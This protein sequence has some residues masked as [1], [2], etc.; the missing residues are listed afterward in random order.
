VALNCAALAE[1]LLESELFGHEKGAFTGATQMKRGRFELAH[2]GT[3]FLDEIG[4]MSVNLQPK[5][6]RVLQERQFERLG[7]GERLITVDVRVIAATNRDLAHAMEE[8]AF[9]EDLYYRL[10]V[11]PIQIPPLRDRREDIIPLAEH[12][13]GKISARMGEP[14]KPLSPEM[15]QILSGYDWPGNVRELQNA[16]ERA[17]IN[18]GDRLAVR[19]FRSTRFQ[20]A[21]VALELQNLTTGSAL[22]LRGEASAPRTAE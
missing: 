4:D 10:N 11:F 12:F 14:P 5:L 19:A 13:A 15:Q 2:T 1:T 3:L 18:P 7:G 22:T 9:R 16:L 21:Y 6:L 8:K 20:D 17:L